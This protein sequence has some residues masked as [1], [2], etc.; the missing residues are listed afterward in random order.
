MN[1]IIKSLKKSE[2]GKRLA[3]IIV[4]IINI[5]MLSIF[6]M[7]ATGL[8]DV[9]NARFDTSDVSQIIFILFPVVGISIICIL[10]L[11]WIVMTLTKSIFESREKF[12]VNLRLIGASKE[13]LQYI[14]VK[15]MLLIQLITIPIGIF[16]A[17]IFWRCFLS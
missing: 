8:K 16:L 7:L 11:Q 5:A 9:Y 17:E 13:G 1:Q 12:N 4:Y 14:Y 6:M 2:K 10:I 3:L 15:E